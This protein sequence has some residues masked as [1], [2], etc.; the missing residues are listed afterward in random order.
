ME[1][2]AISNKIPV[3]ILDTKG[4]GEV[5]ILLHGYL[6]TLYIFNELIEKLSQKYRVI[7]ID[8]PGHGLTGTDKEENSMEFCAKVVVG[9]L[10]ICKVEKV[11]IA[12]HSMGGYIAQNCISLYPDRFKGLILLN[13]TPF[14][15]APEKR[16]N[17]DKEINLILNSKLNTIAAIS[18]P[19]MYAAKNRRNCDEKIEET[20]EIVETHDPNGIVAS[21]RGLMS[22]KETKDVL[23]NLSKGLFIFG[24]EDFYIS[25]EVSNNLI[26]EFPNMQHIKIEGTGHNS[27]IEDLDTTSNAIFKFIG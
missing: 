27:F 26:L 1:F 21:L 3:H 18:I 12:G 25:N 7:A 22:R 16:E 6:E 2:F 11:Y 5:I 8:L 4:E 23:K 19:N 14:A 20:V 17:R 10:D 24:D 15:D 9:A 13:S